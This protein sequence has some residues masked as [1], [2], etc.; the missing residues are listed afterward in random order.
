MN[1][2]LILNPPASRGG[3]YNFEK[4][5]KR[6]RFIKAVSTLML[7]S[8]IGLLAG[9]LV[10]HILELQDYLRQDALLPK[11]LGHHIL[12]FGLKSALLSAVGAASIAPSVRD[13]KIARLRP[14]LCLLLLLISAIPFFT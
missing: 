11:L 4:E 10:I 3:F 12:A 13:E 14:W 7:A 2:V 1:G 8:I 9:L 5:D 6:F